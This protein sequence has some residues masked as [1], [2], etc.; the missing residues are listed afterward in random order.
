M[1]YG[2]HSI[3]MDISR[4]SLNGIWQPISNYTAVQLA[5]IMDIKLKYLPPESE[6]VCWAEVFSLLLVTAIGDPF[7]MD[8]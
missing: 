6:N 1:A 8:F 3:R 7:S 5:F 4:L 2:L